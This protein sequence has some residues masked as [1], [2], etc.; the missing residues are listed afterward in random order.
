[1]VAQSFARLVFGLKYSTGV[2]DTDQ[3]E[4]ITL[5]ETLL[6]SSGGYGQFQFSENKICFQLHYDSH[7]S[8]SECIA[9]AEAQESS[10]S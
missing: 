5:T 2:Y 3:Y 10:T 7:C 1:M 6:K 9:C 4:N 8:T